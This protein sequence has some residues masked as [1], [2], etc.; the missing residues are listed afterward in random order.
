MLACPPQALRFVQEAAH[1]EKLG[2][3][4][5][6]AYLLTRSS[7]PCALLSKPSKAPV[8]RLTLCWICSVSCFHRCNLHAR[9]FS[10]MLTSWNV[11]LV[12]ILCFNC[13]REL[14]P[15]CLVASSTLQFKCRVGIRFRLAWLIQIIPF[16]FNE[17]QQRA[18]ATVYTNHGHKWI[19]KRERHHA[20]TAQR[21]SHSNDNWK[22]QQ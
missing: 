9:T 11:L 13:R 1:A 10:S 8:G 17:E 22:W 20:V 6:G 16:T 18:F 4:I 14:L 21:Y 7:S 5:K 12:A 3:A 19:P 2:R 15:Y